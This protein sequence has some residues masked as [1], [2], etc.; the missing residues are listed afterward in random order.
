MQTVGLAVVTY[1]D[2]F[3]SALQTYA[4]Q[5]VLNDLGYETGIFDIQGVHRDVNRK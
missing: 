4:T 2:N 1:K 5:R 3:G